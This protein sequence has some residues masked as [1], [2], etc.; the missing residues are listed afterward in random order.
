MLRNTLL[1]RP[2]ALAGIF[3]TT[4][5]I[6]SFQAICKIFPPSSQTPIGN[7]SFTPETSIQYDAILA[8]ISKLSNT[9]SQ[10]NTSLASLHMK[11]NSSLIINCPQLK[12]QNFHSPNSSH[13][14]SAEEKVVICSI[15]PGVLFLAGILVFFGEASHVSEAFVTRCLL[16]TIGMANVGLAIVV[17]W[18]SYL[19]WDKY[20][21]VT[22]WSVALSMIRVAILGVNGQET[23]LVAENAEKVLKKE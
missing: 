5:S 11:T 13:T 10:I 15:L 2:E 23:Q 8:A 16:V 6:L 4:V 14:M 9:L 7:P 20:I 18:G 12:D 21:S 3:M 1:A 22:A 19:R 17:F